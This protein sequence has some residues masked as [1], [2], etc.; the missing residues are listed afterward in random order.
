MI[1]LKAF[2][3]D[4]CWPFNLSQ[5]TAA[6]QLFISWTTGA[7]NVVSMEEVQ[8]SIMNQQDSTLK[9]HFLLSPLQSKGRNDCSGSVFILSS[10]VWQ[11]WHER[12]YILESVCCQ[13]YITFF[14]ITVLFFS[15]RK[16]R[17]RHSCDKKS[18]L[19]VQPFWG[20]TRCRCVYECA[21]RWWCRGMYTFWLVLLFAHIS[22]VIHLVQCPQ[23]V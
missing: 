14:H 21:V 19:G 15:H 16:Q 23:I 18:L 7:W 10:F 12:V 17:R 3:H 11:G 8:Y 6:C 9:F 22:N 2:A 4:K 20:I 13:A 1:K 5:F